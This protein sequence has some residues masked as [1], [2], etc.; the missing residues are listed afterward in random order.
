MVG[1]G[2]AALPPS[3][4]KTAPRIARMPAAQAPYFGA[5]ISA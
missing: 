3:A 5:V 2:G 1:T 4:P